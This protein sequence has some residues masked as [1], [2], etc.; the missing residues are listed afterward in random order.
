M[1]QLVKVARTPGGPVYQFEF[2]WALE[3]D[4]IY[5]DLSHKNGAPFTDVDRELTGPPGCPSV[6]CMAGNDGSQCDYPAQKDCVTKGVLTGYLC[7]HP[8]SKTSQ[9]KPVGIWELPKVGQLA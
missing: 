2:V 3:D 8:G 4:K 1:E 7:G 9:S 6:M 5:Y